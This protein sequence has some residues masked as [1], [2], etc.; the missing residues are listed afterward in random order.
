MPLDSAERLYIERQVTLARAIL[1]ALALVALLETSPAPVKRSAVI[2]LSF[3]LVVLAGN[4]AG[5]AVFQ[6]LAPADPAHGRCCGAGGI[7]VSDAFGVRL[8][9]SAAVFSFR[10]QLAREFADHARPCRR[11]N[12]RSNRARCEFGR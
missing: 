7:P 1:V 4:G 8:L 9:V 2:F 6:R 10:S 3:Y 11:R 5:G 12:A